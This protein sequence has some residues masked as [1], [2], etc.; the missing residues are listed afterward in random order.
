MIELVQRNPNRALV[1]KAHQAKIVRD[2][3]RVAAQHDVPFYAVITDLKR[4]E[5]IKCVSKDGIDGIPLVL[6]R[7]TEVDGA[8]NVREVL[9]HFLRAHPADLGVH[10]E[11]ISFPFKGI[12]GG[13]VTITER[14]GKGA[15]GRVWAVVEKPTWV[16]KEFADSGAATSEKAALTMMHGVAGVPTLVASSALRLL[17]DPRGKDLQDALSKTT[18]VH[19]T[20]LLW[21]VVATTVGALRE[22]HSKR[23]V[24]RDVRATNVVIAGTP[25]LIDWASACPAGEA[26]AYSGTTHFAS[27]A[28]LE[29][30]AESAD[31]VK[32]F[33]ADDLESLVLTIAAELDRDLLVE[34]SSIKRDAPR[35]I[36]EF[37]ST[38][39]S[40]WP[41]LGGLVALAREAKYDEL[42]QQAPWQ[43]L[44]SPA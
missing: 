5:V 26:T 27:G 12:E 1:N 24:H 16:V 9:T 29:Q 30:Y 25:V 20:S 39:I 33:P 38:K 23:L 32:V 2:M 7:F 42:L 18:G 28:V 21:S 15:H 40:K 34:L 8:D 35:R 41:A 14:L 22:A 3:A 31:G 36:A 10:P 6:Q 43:A 19:Y 11:N 44:W 37:W 4:L 17:M 13:L